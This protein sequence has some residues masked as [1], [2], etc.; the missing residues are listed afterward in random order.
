MAAER[1]ESDS[2]HELRLE[3]LGLLL[4]GGLL[5]A[6]IVGSFFLGRWVERRAHPTETLTADASGPLAQITNHEPD[7]EAA[8]GL[9]HFDTLEGQGKQTEP[10]REAVEPRTPP[11]VD[12]RTAP[13][14]DESTAPP[15][16][17]VDNGDFF[18]QVV[19]VRDQSAAA[20][21][22]RS[23]E[24]KGYE[25]RLFSEREGQGTLYKVR[26]G[27]YATREKAGTARDALRSTGHPGAF[28]W[29]TG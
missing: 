23:L 18:V 20:E 17:P 5:L 24:A 26:V 21:V 29:T 4:G 19:A 7:L 6:L 14:G 9:T 28:V 22:I 16:A 12:T 11:V 13:T 2:S 3:G 15:V 27:G 8:E 10:E 1:H 25:V